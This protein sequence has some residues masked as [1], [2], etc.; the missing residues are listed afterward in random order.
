MRLSTEAREV[1]RSG[2]FPESTFKIAATAKAFDI[3][4][5]QLY[6]DPRLAI[7]R[8][9]STNAWDAQVEAG[10]QDKPFKVHLPNHFAPFFS[11]RD[12][13]TGLS[14]EQVESIYTT[15]FASTRNDSN[16]YV[17]A[18]GLGSK[19]PFSYTDQFTITSY[20]R[21]TAYIYSAFK[22]ENGEPTITIIS[23]DPTDEPNGI[24][25]KINILEGD[26]GDFQYAAKKVYRF[27]PVR[28][29]ITGA[30]IDFP[31]KTPRFQG[32]GY[33]LYDASSP[34][35]HPELNSTINIVMGNI[36]YP[37]DRNKFQTK[38]GQSGILLLFVDIGECEIAA[39]REELHYSKSTIDNIQRRIDAALEEV[40]REIESKL[41][42]NLCLVE[43]IK[44]LRTYQNI[45]Q[46]AYNAQTIPTELDKAYSLKRVELRGDKVFIGRDIF[47]ST[48]NPQSNTKY[49][50]I[51][52]DVDGD[53]KQSDKGKLR[54]YLRPIRDAIFYLAKIEDR[55]IFSDTFGAVNAE[56]S[57]LP[58]PPKVARVGY[59]GPRTFIKLA[60]NR[61]RARMQYEWSNVDGDV[62]VNKAIA[63]RRDG[64][65]AVINGQ[66]RNAPD[67]CD[68][69][70]VMGYDIVYG[71]AS[72][73]YDRIRKQ[74]GLP[75]FDEEARE[76][77][78]DAVD[79]MDEYVRSR[80][81][82]GTDYRYEHTFL[83]YINGLSDTCDNLVKMHKAKEVDPVL[84]AII[85]GYGITVPD[86]PNF[87]LEFTARYPLL[88][89][90]SLSFANQN[91]IIE[92]I[93]LKEK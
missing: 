91:D 35:G 28:P 24:E 61:R 64:Y 47:Q 45:L 66:Q 87:K 13:G 16:D 2:P 26:E 72:T 77:A 40:N 76:F 23:D 36:C 71:I 32:N 42:Q 19:S 81:H 50:I 88:A 74:L 80:R 62:D 18:L 49:V 31:Q 84:N 68:M 86:A 70:K 34:N 51:E 38:M 14:P 53:L 52:N 7:V 85:N 15:Y 57:K 65:Y 83:K 46:F 22:N 9:L 5:K 63:V 37:V 12:F 48:I 75:D 92:Y 25:I 29:E 20:W 69:A 27:F 21:G 93:T 6:K 58:D 54:H 11:I 73:Y 44:A 82:H 4:S 39:S 8:E 79:N 30:K 67:V 10:N 56:L 3:L 55:Q 59:T 60:S 33:H 17:G 41:T 78:K 90:V 89:N 43:K 1:Q